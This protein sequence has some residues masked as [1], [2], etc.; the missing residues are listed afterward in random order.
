MRRLLTSRRTNRLVA[1]SA[2]ALALTACADGPT[3]P[4]AL[5]SAEP[6]ANIAAQASDGAT[7]IRKAVTTIPFDVAIANDCDWELVQLDGELRGVSFQ[8]RDA[9][10][11][12]H[13][14][15]HNNPMGIGGVGLTSGDAYRL[16]GA[17][18]TQTIGEGGDRSFHQAAS[19]RLIRHGAADDLHVQFVFAFELVDGQFVGRIAKVTVECR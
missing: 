15:F 11:T 16:V 9:N 12:F 14:T 13:W 17:E 4:P 2:A 19:S 8:R 18:T 5:A 10:G 3:A 7:I 6:A 1:A